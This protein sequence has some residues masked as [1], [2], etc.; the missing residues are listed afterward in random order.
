MTGGRDDRIHLD[1]GLQTRAGIRAPEQSVQ[2][3]AAGVGNLFRVIKPY[4]VPV[5]DPL[6]GHSRDVRPQ[7]LLIEGVRRLHDEP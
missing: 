7:D 2:A 5:V 1:D 3:D 4:R 6:Q